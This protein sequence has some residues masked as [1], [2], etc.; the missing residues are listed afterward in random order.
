MLLPYLEE[1]SLYE[2]LEP[3]AN[4]LQTIRE[5]NVRLLQ[6]PLAVFRCPSDNGSATNDLR[7]LDMS[8]EW[9]VPVARS[10]YVGNTGT[11]QYGPWPDETNPDFLEPN[12]L[13]DFNRTV[14][15]SDVLDGLSK[16]FAVGERFG[17]ESAIIMD[18]S[19]TAR[20]P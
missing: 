13:F 16:T 8:G 10:N 7:L 9:P 4:T 15:L 12:G 18:G 1:G 3:E 20:A 11:G 19:Q 2:E 14:R 17:Q 5:A 6:L